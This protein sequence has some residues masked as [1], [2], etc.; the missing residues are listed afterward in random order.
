MLRPVVLLVLIVLF[1]SCNPGQN[2]E[3]EKEIEQTSDT[4][5]KNSESRLSEQMKV[6]EGRKI[7]ENRSSAMRL[8]ETHEGTKVWGILLRMSKW[9]R[10]AHENGYTIL[11]PSDDVIREAG[12]YAIAE[13]KYPENKELLDK[14]M[15]KH[16]ITTPVVIDK[17][18]EKQEVKTIDG[19][20]LLIDPGNRT[21]GGAKFSTLSLQSKKGW[22]IVMNGIIDLPLEQLRTM[23]AKRRAGQ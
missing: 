14:I 8:A 6:A 5:S 3:T 21:I 16:I 7:E 12:L 9:A 1:F 17:I 19:K 10:E 23:E 22:V 20:T 13:L 2:R 11:A 18:I 4:V 15:A